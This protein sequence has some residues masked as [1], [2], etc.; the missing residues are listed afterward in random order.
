M[1]S[2]SFDTE[3]APGLRGPGADMWRTAAAWLW[4]SYLALVTGA[5][6]WWVF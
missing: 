5:I 6:L 4:A 3:E 2:R 1:A